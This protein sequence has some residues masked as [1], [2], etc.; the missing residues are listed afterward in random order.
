[1]PMPRATFSVQFYAKI[2][3]TKI[4]ERNEKHFAEN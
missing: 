3:T 2:T 4:S 1:M